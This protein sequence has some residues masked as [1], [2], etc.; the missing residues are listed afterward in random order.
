MNSN[1]SIGACCIADT[2]YELQ[3]LPEFA[4]KTAFPYGDLDITIVR[5]DRE[6][7]G[8]TFG[9]TGLD[10]VE[11]RLETADYAILGH[12]GLGGVE[13]KNPKDAV[14]SML[15]GR[16]SNYKAE[17]ERAEAFEE[18]MI[19]VVEAPRS[20]FE[21]ERYYSQLPWWEFFNCIDELEQEFRAEFIF[22]DG[23]Q[24]AERRTLRYLL[25]LANKHIDGVH[26]DMRWTHVC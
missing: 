26:A 3:A 9:G 23:R 21:N 18:R 11:Q 12:E 13:R 6:K 1:Y 17:H 22:H 7:T 19:N 8:F 24:E 4:D 2:S 20:Y 15:S 16:F 10:V 25:N 14:S 5:D